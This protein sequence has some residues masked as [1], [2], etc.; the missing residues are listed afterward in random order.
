LSFF[1]KQQS[2]YTL[3]KSDIPLISNLSIIENIALIQEVQQKI[4]ASLV[5]RQIMQILQSI[6]MEHIARQRVSSCNEF[7]LFC[8]M[9]IRSL[10]AK[11]IQVY[12]VTPFTLISTLTSL[13]EITDILEKLD[14]KK[15]IMILDLQNNQS[16]YEGTL[17]HIIK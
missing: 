3:V 1:L 8:A 4:S 10:Q 7:E 12:I 2:G 6:N 16:N 9:L 11:E 13:K 14:L 17:C 5:E 15:D